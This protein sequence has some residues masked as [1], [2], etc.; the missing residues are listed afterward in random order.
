[1]RGLEFALSA[2]RLTT[3]YGVLKHADLRQVI[4][5]LRSLTTAYGVL[6][7]APVAPQG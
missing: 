6:K 1:M 5:D 2:S 4:T 7:L 3:A